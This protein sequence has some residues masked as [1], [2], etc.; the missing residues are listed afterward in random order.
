VPSTCALSYIAAS[1]QALSN[2]LSA[3]SYSSGMESSR[4]AKSNTE[5]YLVEA[6]RLKAKEHTS[7]DT[8]SD[9]I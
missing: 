5:H 6:V 9:Q 7:L 2:Q 3:I 4:A 1:P 8:I